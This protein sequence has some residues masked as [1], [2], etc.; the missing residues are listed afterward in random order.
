MAKRPLRLGVIGAG[1]VAQV[2]HLPVLK[3][4]RDLEV[5]A[6]C[7]DDG[8]RARLVAQHFGIPRVTSDYE[9]LLRGDEV[10]AVIIATPNHLHAPMTLAALGYG[11][12]VLC[13]KPPARNAAEAEQMAEAAKRAGTVLFYAMNFRFRTDVQMLRGYMERRELGTIFYA[14]TGW[15]LRRTE[16]RRASWYRNKRSA[17]GGVLI[18]MGVQMLDLALWFLGYPKVVSATATKYVSDPRE[19]VE[20]TVAAFLI[21]ESGASLTL[22]VSWAL[23]L[24][25]NFPYLNLF[26]THGAAH[27]KPFRVLKELSGNLLDVTPSIDPSKSM[28]KQSYEAELDHFI[29]CITHGERPLTTPEEGVQLMR[30]I[31]AI[32]QSAETRR[33]VRLH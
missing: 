29:R 19:D 2:S 3:K 1:S 7:D 20:D 16:T 5:V 8:E 33:E 32:Y 28:H 18:D 31:D 11:K 14:K 23:L 4:R 25:K 13:E 22:E 10:D 12:H 27:L 30:V 21:L 17:G 9:S 24:E 26:G 6:V 15:L